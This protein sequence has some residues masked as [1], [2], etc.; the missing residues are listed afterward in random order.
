MQEMAKKP[1]QQYRKDG[2]PETAFKNAAT[3]IERTY[4]APFLAHNCME[5]MN[6]FAHVE[7]DKALVAEYIQ[8]PGWTEPTL[9]KILNL[10]AD[11]IE[12]K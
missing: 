9:A 2:D 1:A 7:A 6:F 4:N 10:P 3:I 5:P 12:I 11:K 8:A